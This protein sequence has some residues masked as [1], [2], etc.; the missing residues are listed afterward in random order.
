MVS[1]QKRPQQGEKNV[2]SYEDRTYYKVAYKVFRDRVWVS[3]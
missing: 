1:G 2:K 3:E